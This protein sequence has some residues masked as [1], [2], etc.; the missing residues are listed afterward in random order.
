ML[1]NTTQCIL[2][3]ANCA[4]ITGSVIGVN[5][6]YIGTKSSKDY[7]YFEYTHQSSFM[8]YR[9]TSLSYLNGNKGI[10]LVEVLLYNFKRVSV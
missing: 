8:A 10:Q 2:K 4:P 5:D 9:S 6:C 3:N 7:H 1:G